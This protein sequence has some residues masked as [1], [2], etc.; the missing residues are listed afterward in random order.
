MAEIIEFPVEAGGVLRVQ[1]VDDWESGEELVAATGVAEKVAKAKETVET[2]VGSVTPA[3]KAVTGQ[4][5]KLAPDEV[6]VEF[7]LVLGVEHGI[8]LAKGKGEVHFTVT[9]A[10]KDGQGGSEASG[11]DGM[12]VLAA[13]NGDGGLDGGDAVSG[14]DGGA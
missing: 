10:W 13:A 14:Q 1:A 6:T 3:L 4:L 9:L 2:V 5:R 12:A 7:G 8:V 11:A